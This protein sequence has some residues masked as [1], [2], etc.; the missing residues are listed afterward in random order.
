MLSESCVFK[1]GRVYNGNVVCG[2]LE[3]SSPGCFFKALISTGTDKVA[4][5]VFL[6]LGGEKKK[7]LH[8]SVCKCFTFSVYKE[9][10]CP[11]P[12]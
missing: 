11:L 2:L 7:S 6:E 4:V 12:L 3:R 9:A 8:A 10:S 1:K 5:R